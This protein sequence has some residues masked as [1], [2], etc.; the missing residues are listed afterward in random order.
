M[1]CVVV[2]SPDCIVLNELVRENS[3]V[4]DENEIMR[5]PVALVSDYLI[6]QLCFSAYASL[7]Y[8]L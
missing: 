7:L 1:F 3:K 4:Q 2:N 8:M 6:H 5:T